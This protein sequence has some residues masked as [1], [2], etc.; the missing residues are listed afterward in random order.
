MGK[1]IIVAGNFASGKTT[2]T[3]ALY[4]RTNYT[5]F[6]EDPEA[7]PFQVRFTEDMRRWVFANQIDFFTFR[8][9]QDFA[10]KQHSGICIQDGGLDQDM[11]FFTRHLFNQGVLDTL[12][13]ELCQRVYTMYRTL[14]V[15]PD[16]IIRLNASIATILERRAARARESDEKLVKQSE[17]EALEVLLDEWMANVQNIPII[18]V[19]TNHPDFPTSQQLEQLIEQITEHL[20]ILE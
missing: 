9:R 4:E 6:W 10:I 5:P 13:Y 7:R 16:L 2:L 14:L 8:A 3:R 20:G 19:D 1:H 15:P 12:E 18:E 17:L 11:M